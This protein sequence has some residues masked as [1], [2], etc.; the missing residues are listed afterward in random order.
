MYDVVGIGSVLVDELVLLPEF[1]PPDSKIEIINTVKQ[2]G[3][4][5]PTALRQLSELG[6][7]TTFI[8]KI[9]NDSNSTYIKNKLQKS[10]VDTVGLIEEQANS[11]YA[12]VWID[13]KHKTRTIAYS[14]GTLTPLQRSDLKF[15]TLPKARVLHVDARDNDVIIDIINHYKKEGTK[16]SI[17]TGSFRE[18]TLEILEL[19]DLISMPRSFAISLFGDISMKTLAKRMKDRYLFSE[20]IVIT[21]GVNG[22]VCSYGNEIIRQAAFDIE[23]FDTTGAG[24]VHAG[25]LVYGF[26]NQWSI[27]EKLQFASAC[28]A[29]KCLELGNKDLPNLQRVYDFMAQESL[30]QNVAI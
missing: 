24:D 18:Y 2:L 30:R 13:I 16:I 5:V 14:S 6:A 20:S 22:S 28:A 15:E 23:T 29:I 27:Q 26:L 25:S 21:D 17:D 1:P 12:Q 10:N 11:G 8:G 7:Q 3:G 9:G 19:V 4:P